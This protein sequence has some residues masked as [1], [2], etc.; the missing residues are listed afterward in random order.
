MIRSM[1]QTLRL[2]LA[3]AWL[4]Y[5]G[6]FSIT[7]PFGYITSKLGFPFFLML[8]FIFMGKFVGYSNPLYIVI[9]NI[10]LIP[11]ATC[12]SGVTYAIGDERGWGTLS[13]VLGSPAQR[14]PIFV[15]RALYYVLDGFVTALLGFAIAA[16]I[17]R[18]Q[19]SAINFPLLILS[20]FLIAITS[21]GLGFLFG[22][23]SLV[24]R[25][26]WIFLNTFLSLLY[27][28]VG[29]N[30]PV[31]AL[32]AFLQK[33][34]YGLP[35]TRGI[36]AARMALNGAGWSEVSSLVLGE[37]LVGVVYILLGYLCFRLIERRSLASGTL[38]AM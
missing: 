38:D 16:G 8:F 22:S 11:A 28:L 3:Q 27:I 30:F 23:I 4:S 24:S 2:T 25:D 14:G 35:L 36:L 7:S 37:I 1:L 29:V 13:Y 17:F 6:Y 9:G 31:E 10:L 18:L 19:M 26:G 21:S 15:G 34:S 32:P 33:L 20:M 5:Q 12:M